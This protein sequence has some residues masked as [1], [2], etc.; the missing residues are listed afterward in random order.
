MPEWLLKNKIIPGLNCFV[1]LGDP[2][3]DMVSSDL[4]KIDIE[5][6]IEENNYNLNKFFDESE[7][8]EYF[9]RAPTTIPRKNSS[10]TKFHNGIKK[11]NGLNGF[12]NPC[13]PDGKASFFKDYLTQ[14]LDNHL[15]DASLNESI[16]FYEFEGNEDLQKNLENFL[17]LEENKDTYESEFSHIYIKKYKK[18]LE[19]LKSTLEHHQVT[20]ESLVKILYEDFSST[21]FE[22]YIF[23][24]KCNSEYC[25]NLMKNI[26]EK[27]KTNQ[28]TKPSQSNLIPQYSQSNPSNS[29]ELS[30]NCFS[31]SNYMLKSNNINQQAYSIPQQNPINGINTLN[32]SSNGSNRAQST[33]SSLMNGKGPINITPKNNLSTLA[34]LI[35]GQNSFKEEKKVSNGNEGDAQGLS[36]IPRASDSLSMASEIESMAS[37]ASRRFQGQRKYWNE[38]E[39]KEL[40]NLYNQ[41]FPNSIPF[42]KVEE[43][44]RKMGRTV[45]SV[46]TKIQKMKIE[47]QKKQEELAI[48][49]LKSKGV[50][51]L[52]NRMKPNKRYEI[53]LEKMIKTAVSQF[54]NQ[55]AT[56]SEI[57]TKVKEIFFSGQTPPNEEAWLNSLSQLISSSKQF[58]KFK[59]TYTLKSPYYLMEDINQAKTLKGR[60]IFILSMLPNMS[61]D[62]NTIRWMFQEYFKDSTILEK[63]KTWETSIIKTLKQNYEFDS[64]NCKTKYTINPEYSS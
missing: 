20:P 64:L 35:D 30:S 51:Q 57:I 32:H 33:V 29:Q 38:Q 17:F 1:T 27:K 28:E 26:T 16:K 43:F 3:D 21:L 25:F 12:K 44:S 56:K 2:D 59:G 48:E 62:I 45:C 58:K 19:K 60:L 22:L 11:N 31:T 13:K 52:N 54:P 36:T 50:S 53:P 47:F 49:N 42:D 9:N 23:I 14:M 5:H 15:Y 39:S 34:Q 37:D 24:K 61:G 63:D 6:L 4:N 18:L 40:E 41:Y 10:N 55:L 8:K 46:Q 7:K